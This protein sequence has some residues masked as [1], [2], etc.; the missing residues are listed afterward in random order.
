M[1][2]EIASEGLEGV[3]AAKTILSHADGERG[4]VWVRGHTIDEL[5][6]RHGYERP[7]IKANKVTTASPETASRARPLPESLAPPARSSFPG[8]TTGCRPPHAGH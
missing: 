2:A 1:N 5:V 8:S 7:A 3:V 4:I 6:A